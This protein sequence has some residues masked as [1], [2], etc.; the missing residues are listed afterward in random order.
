MMERM[1]GGKEAK[2]WNFKGASVQGIPIR[3]HGALVLLI[4]IGFLV[5]GVYVWGRFHSKL[6]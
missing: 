5:F 3:A 2:E 4:A 6:I 1:R